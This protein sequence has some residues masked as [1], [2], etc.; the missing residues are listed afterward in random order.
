MKSEIIIK[1]RSVAR[2]ST[3][4]PLNLQLLPLAITPS[5]TMAFQRVCTDTVSL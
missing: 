4:R 5:I 3:V 1:S 2:V